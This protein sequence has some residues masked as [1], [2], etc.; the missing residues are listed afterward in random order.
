MA[1]LGL[2]FLPQVASNQLT[3]LPAD[4]ESFLVS[5]LRDTPA[6]S[7]P[8]M[9]RI[10]QTLHAPRARLIAM[11][12]GGFS[13]GT[14]PAL[15]AFVLRHAAGAATRIGYIATASGYEATAI[16]RFH[17]RFERHCAHTTDMPP[18]MQGTPA[19][20][21]LQSLDTVFVG[22]G[23]T[24]RLLALWREAGLDRLLLDA[25][26]EGLLLAGVSAGAMVWFEAGLSDA[27]GAG[28]APLPGLGLFSGSFCP[29]YDSEPQR[30][31]ALHTAIASGQLPRGLA[32]DDGAAVLL[33]ASGVREVCLA[34]PHCS[35]Y[36]L[37]A[38]LGRCLSRQLA[39][40]A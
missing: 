6:T 32:L 1:R 34:R 14:D 30:Q 18:G 27:L 9:Q 19:A 20:Q 15:E 21:W 2:V 35:A 26:G 24:A 13:Q 38:R 31:P 8:F 7:T 22:G 36:F 39:A 25:A 5:I 29:H 28:L 10:P 17:Q 33:D 37:H 3:V 12:G 11:G 23:N 4:D 40:P 16:A